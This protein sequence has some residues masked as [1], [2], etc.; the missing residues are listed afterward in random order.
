MHHK[1]TNLDLSWAEILCLHAQTLAAD[2]DHTAQ[3]MITLTRKDTRSQGFLKGV[4]ICTATARV[5]L[6]G[7]PMMLLV[8]ISKM[9]SCWIIEQ[10]QLLATAALICE[11]THRYAL[12][13]RK[14]KTAQRFLHQTGNDA[15][16]LRL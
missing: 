8:E 7:F 3:E 4:T 5:L 14:V 10:K 2:A 16:K 13:Q 12:F 1:K 9:K 15:S 6:S 11:H